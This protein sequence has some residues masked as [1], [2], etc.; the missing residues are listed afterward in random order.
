MFASAPLPISSVGALLGCMPCLHRPTMPSLPM[1]S[2]QKKISSN[3]GRQGCSGIFAMLLA[4]L[5]LSGLPAAATVV[6][7][8][9]I[10]V[11]TGLITSRELSGGVDWLD[12]NTL[13]VTAPIADRP[14]YFRKLV[15]FDLRS[16]EIRTLFPLGFLDCVNRTDGIVGVSIGDLSKSL[17]GGSTAS[18]PVQKF[19]RWNAARQKLDNVRVDASKWHPQLCRSMAP[20]DAKRHALEMGRDTVRFLEGRDGTIKW[21]SGI[22]DVSVTRAPESSFPLTLHRPGVKPMQLDARSDEIGLAPLYLPFLKSYM[23]LSGQ[24]ALGGVFNFRGTETSQLPVVLMTKAGAISRLRV[25]AELMEH[26]AKVRANGSATVIP[27]AAGQ[28]TVALTKWSKHG[29][30]IFLATEG[31]TARIWCN[32][33]PTEPEPTCE[34]RQVAAISPDGCKIAFDSDFPRGK[35]WEPTIRIVELCKK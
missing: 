19:F 24:A 31:A 25:S 5:F 10:V 17:E 22:P 7:A 29:A 35:Q 1:N 12:A 20:E 26:F 3:R 34:I 2:S 8:P 21:E 18:D 14:F 6:E 9:A 16:K 23:L 30:G 27:S 4:A 33:S 15:T 11:D 32:P 13:A 28:L